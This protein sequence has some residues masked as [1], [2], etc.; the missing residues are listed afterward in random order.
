MTK[1][2]R[3]DIDLSV[4]K[5]LFLDQAW[6]HL[7]NLRQNLA[8]L[9]DDPSDKEA[10]YEAHRAAHT[11]KGMAA[12]MRYET[13]ATL[14]QNLERPFISGSPLARDQMDTLLIGCDEFER[15]LE[16]LGAADDG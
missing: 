2:K 5:G 14:A 4:Y 15:G 7:S 11:L 10:Q 13:L 6:Q 16:Q 3:A 9:R 12:T 1:R 8:R